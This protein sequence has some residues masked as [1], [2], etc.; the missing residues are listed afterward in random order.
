MEVSTI[1]FTNHTL[2]YVAEFKKIEIKFVVSNNLSI[3]LT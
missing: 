3:I 1:F 2:A